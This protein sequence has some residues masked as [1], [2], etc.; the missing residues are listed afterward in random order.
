MEEREVYSEP[1][2]RMIVRGSDTETIEEVSDE[3]PCAVSVD[4]FLDT[5]IHDGKV[6]LELR[7]GDTIQQGRFFDDLKLAQIEI[8]VPDRSSS[9]W[10]GTW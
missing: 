8:S 4:A 3:D 5:Q 9:R 1:D 7:F 6:V 2:V 10:E